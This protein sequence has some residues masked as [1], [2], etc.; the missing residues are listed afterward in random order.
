MWLGQIVS[1]LGDWL[2]TMAIYSLI[3][4]ITGSGLAMAAIMMVKLLPTVIISPVA[5]VVADRLDKKKVM[6]STDL[7]RFFTVLG[8][9][10]VESKNELWLLY[11]LIPAH[12]NVLGRLSFQEVNNFRLH[13]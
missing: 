12:E 8:F 2:N 9:L 5:G 4:S 3:L 7:A 10:L 6:I 1:Q 13:Q 11:A